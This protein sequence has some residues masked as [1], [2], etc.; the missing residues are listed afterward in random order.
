[1]KKRR[2]LSIMFPAVIAWFTFA[3][4]R[5]GICEEKDTGQVVASAFGQP[6]APYVEHLCLDGRELVCDRESGILY[7]TLPETLRGGADYE[8]VLSADYVSSRLSAGGDESLPMKEK[9]T[10]GYHLVV[11]DT[12]ALPGGKL[13]FSAVSCL[14]DY[15]VSLMDAGGNVLQRHPLRFT[16]LP[17]IEITLPGCTSATFTRGSI[18]LTQADAD[19]VYAGDAMFRHRGASSLRYA[20]KNYAV[21]L[22]DADGQA[23]DRRLLGLRDDNSWV[24]DAMTIDK[25]CMRNRVSTD[26]W[27]DFSTPPY[28]RREGW[29]RKAKTGARG[30][31]VEVFLNGTYHGLYCLSEKIDRKQLKLKKYVPPSGASDMLHGVLYKSV[32]YCPETTMRVGV[33]PGAYD[34]DAPGGV[35]TGFEV[36]YPDRESERIDW[37]PLWNAVNFAANS[38]DEEFAAGIGTYFDLPVLIDLMLFIDVAY[39]ADNTGKNLYY[40]V[41]DVQDERYGST[42]GVAVWDVDFSWGRNWEG[43]DLYRDYSIPFAYYNNWQLLNRLSAVK[44]L[45]W[46]ERLCRRYA[47]LRKGEFSA[48]RMTRRFTS[49]RALLTESGADLREQQRWPEF[50]DD[51]AGDVDDISVWIERRLGFLDGVYAYNPEPLGIKDVPDADACLYAAGG[52]GCMVLRTSRPQ[53]VTL[54]T[55]DGRLVRRVALTEACTTVGGLHPGWYI[56]AG[57]KVWVRR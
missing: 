48:E 14:R 40:Y 31:F 53:T 33:T 5:A 18:R 56:V 6:F 28:H 17:L 45:A 36:K 8:A 22:C 38:T 11:E 7:A 52:S 10:S 46:N 55:P 12:E 13:R 39:A 47:E 42:L 4:V 50:H 3:S 35:W 24:L 29:E 25:A 1:M 41:Y 21:K 23:M 27:N 15:M 51:I 43:K 19:T 26:L 2:L 16:Y 37:G 32:S 44:G 57:R 54:Y 20:K 34:N 49:Y 9:E 30:R